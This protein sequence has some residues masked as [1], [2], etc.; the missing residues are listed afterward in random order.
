MPSK[1]KSANDTVQLN[2]MGWM[3]TFS[4]LVTLLL[5]FFVLL[6]SMSSMDVRSIKQAF[7]LFFTGASG[8]LNY[9]TEGQMQD[10]ARFLEKM[11]TVPAGELL[12]QQDFKEALFQ[13]EDVEYN[14]LMSLVD[15]DINVQLEK[16]GL[17][18]QL[19]DYILFSEGGAVLRPEYLPILNR[20]ASFLRATHY[21]ISIE[22]HTDASPLEGPND[23]WAWELSLERALAVLAY[24]T[25]EEGLLMERFRVAGYGA[26]KP[27]VPN[28]TPRNR[29]RNRRIEII[30]YKETLS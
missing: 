4:D 6:I 25:D 23:A 3:V 14:R 29:A 22:G 17:V 5:T 13:F 20:I 28:D 12:N 7:G 27:I 8:V 19:A 26:S 9:S 16:R 1:K 11:D 18:I 30:L 15:R 10:M 2:P 24:F 21:P